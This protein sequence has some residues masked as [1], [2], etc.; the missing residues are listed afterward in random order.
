MTYLST[1]KFG[2]EM[3]LSCAF[4]QHKANSHCKFIHG[5]SLA[6]KF[7]FQTE[8]LDERNWVVDFGSLKQLKIKLQQTFDHT[9]VVAKDDP[10]IS[11]FRELD[12]I[13]WQLFETVEVGC[14][15]FAKLA[16]DYA[17]LNVAPHIKVISCECAEHEANSAIYL[18]EF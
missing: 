11:H 5:Y 10:L 13:A 16:Y 3:G 12:G 6:F 14:E 8:Q 2:H 1:K 9:L 7:V 18:G 15:A 17:C 4:R